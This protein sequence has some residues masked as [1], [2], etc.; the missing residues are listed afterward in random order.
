MTDGYTYLASPYTSDDP[1]V[2]EQRYKAAR[3]C[4]AWLLTNKLWVFSPIV[5]SHDMSLACNLPYEAEKY[6]FWKE[7]DRTMLRSARDMLILAIDGWME[8]IGVTDELAY[9]TSI[10]KT[11][12]LIKQLDDG[13]TREWHYPKQMAV[14]A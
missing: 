6:E 3:N 10:G 8:S 11:I 9:A 13:Y 1:Q 14:F 12:G 4:A 5:H 7:Y 2:R